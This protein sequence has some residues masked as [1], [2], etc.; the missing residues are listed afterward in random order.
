[1]RQRPALTIAALFWSSAAAAAQLVTY[2]SPCECFE[3]HGKHRWV[4]KNDPATSPTDASAIQAATP[5]DIFNWQGPTEYYDLMSHT[6]PCCRRVFIAA[7]CAHITF[8]ALPGTAGA[9]KRRV[10]GTRI[11][12]L[13]N[14]TA[15]I[16]VSNDFHFVGRIPFTIG[17]IASGERIV[18]AKT[19]GKL[20]ERLFVV[21]F[22][23]ILPKSKEE[24]RYDISNG[25]QIGGLRFRTSTFAYSSDEAA[26]QNPL[27]EAPLMSAF[28]K[29]EG[30][31]VSDELMAA[32][33]ATIAGAGRRHEMIIFYLQP[34][35]A[36]GFKRSDLYG[37][38][39]QPSEIGRKLGAQL[40]QESLRVFHIA[41]SSEPNAILRSGPNSISSRYGGN[42]LTNR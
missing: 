33:F 15:T 6:L 29:R 10:L 3:N 13:S 34:V 21:Q 36:T 4:A 37:T 35:A 25:L 1:M 2:Q 20:V 30:Y 22:E 26:R 23:S 12:S 28:L 27:G 14:P 32:R 24:Y 31:I 8:R 38:N 17:E 42:N 41:A 18:F 11:V 16:T 5:S 40:T 19:R 39:E 9:P 7:L